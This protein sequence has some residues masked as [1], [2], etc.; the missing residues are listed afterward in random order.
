MMA[1]PDGDAAGEGEGDELVRIGV[2]AERRDAR[3]VPADALQHPSDR[4][5][6]EGEERAIAEDK[7][8]KADI[9]EGDAALEVE[10]R[11]RPQRKLRLDVDIGAIGAA[12][13]AAVVEQRIRHLAEGKRHHDEVE[14]ARQHGE[15]ADGERRDPGERHRAAE[16]DE[17]VGAGIGRRQE[18][19]RIRADPEEH[20]VPE[21]HQPTHADQQVEAEHEDGEDDDAGDE[22]DGIGA[23]EE[24][25]R[26]RGEQQRGEHGH[27]GRRR[28]PEH[29]TPAP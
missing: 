28:T 14:A 24:R 15:R 4:P 26:R 7:Q 19:D 2:V 13:E 1:S 5:A 23:A 20:R 17:R 12:G 11:R 3:L 16:G 22:L 27:G 21:A 18:V 29:L 8:R 9:E 6:R 10:E 25:R